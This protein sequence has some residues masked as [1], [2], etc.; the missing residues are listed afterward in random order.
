MQHI[1]VR[2]KEQRVRRKSQILAECQQLFAE[3]LRQFT[4]D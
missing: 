4:P 2:G 1:A 3:R